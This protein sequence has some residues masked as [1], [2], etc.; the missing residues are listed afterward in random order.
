VLRFR[1]LLKEFSAAGW[2]NRAERDDFA[3][4][5]ADADGADLAKL[6][7]LLANLPGVTRDQRRNRLQA[8][9]LLTEGKSDQ[10]LFAPLFKLTR[11][12]E[13]ASRRVLLPVL[14]RSSDAR[15]HPEIA[16]L[17]T[18]ADTDTRRWGATVMKAV[19]GG[20]TALKALTPILRRP[21]GPRMEAMHVAME[22]GGHYAIEIV[23]PVLENGIVQERLAAL[24]LIGDIRYARVHPSRAPPGG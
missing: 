21:G 17:L 10:R 4:R 23:A 13:E 19:G 20:K 12:G 16:A 3:A 8:F 2:R 11:E 22:I 9:I 15:N 18:A 24:R 5:S 1:S 7:P 14:G 6:V